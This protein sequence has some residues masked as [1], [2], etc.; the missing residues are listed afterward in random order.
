MKITDKADLLYPDAKAKEYGEKRRRENASLPQSF[1]NDLEAYRTAVQLLPSQPDTVMNLMREFSD[2]I[3]T[4]NY[5]LDCLEDHLNEPRL[6]DQLRPIMRRL[7]DNNT[8]TAQL[9]GKADSF[10]EINLRMQQLTEFVSCVEDI[11][12]LWTKIEKRIKSDAVKGLFAAFL[13]LN[14]DKDYQ[15]MKQE[16]SALSEIFSHTVRSVR[17]GINFAHGMIPE[18]CGLIEVS[19]D[20]I[21]PRSG[22]LDKL[23]FRTFEGKEQFIGEE[24]TNS[25][26]HDLPPDMDTALFKSLSKYTREFAQRISDALSARR[27]LFL[28]DITLLEHQ[29]DLYEGAARMVK[30]VRSRGLQMCRPKLL[31]ADFRKAE[32]TGLFDPLLF[33]QTANADYTASGEKLVVTNSLTLDGTARFKLVTG[34]NAGGKTTFARAFGMCRLLAQCGLYVHASSAELS[35]CDHIY[36]HFPQEETAG[37]NTSR[38]TEEVR[39]LAEICDCITPRS[40]VIM[41]ESLQSTTPEE[42]IEIAAIHLE[43]LAASGVSGLYV[44]HL[45]SLYKKVQEI[46]E[47]N[48]P[49]KIGSLVSLPDE[50]TGKSTYRLAERPPLQ[51]S[52]AAA[53]FARYGAKLKGA[54]ERAAANITVDTERSSVV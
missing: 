26:L 35:V 47:R 10:M 43:I 25:A 14:E 13:S 7:S 52:M 39:Q 40:A 46:N 36:T 32:I 4:L 29:L 19:D 45:N 24:H 38:F 31:P 37:I 8:A 3:P 22:I 9:R 15:E 23:I 42:C 30:Y 16:L 28:E 11:G 1:L 21:Y 12:K 6:S 53:I 17:I 2:H 18:S 50:A 48:Y 41:N 54:A 34:V 44:T 49:T 51:Q 5:R 20:K 27:K 33:R